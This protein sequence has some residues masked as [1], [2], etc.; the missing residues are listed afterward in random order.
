[1][2]IASAGFTEKHRPSE[3]ARP[4]FLRIYYSDISEYDAGWNV[5]AW[6]FEK[7]AGICVVSGRLK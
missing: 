5:S 7:P 4:V 6:S 1:L 3:P 2:I